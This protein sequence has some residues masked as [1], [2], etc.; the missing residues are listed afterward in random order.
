MYRCIHSH[1][2]TQRHNPFH[3]CKVDSH[4]HTHT[5]THTHLLGEVLAVL[6]E[7]LDEGVEFA[8]VGLVV[9]MALLEVGHCVCVD[10]CVCVYILLQKVGGLP[11]S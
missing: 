2:Y 1:T 4:T 9:C 5:R 6:C 3:M 11:S 10:V 8:E 7:L